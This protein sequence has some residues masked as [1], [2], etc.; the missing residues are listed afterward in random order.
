MTTRL[1]RGF[2]K[3]A[4]A[5]L[6]CVAAIACKRTEPRAD[7]QE[8]RSDRSPDATGTAAAS[9]A[10]ALSGFDTC[11]VGNFEAEQVTLKLEQVSAAGG[12]KVALQIGADGS[13][14]VDFTPMS[15]I[16]AKANGGLAFDFKYSGKASA[17]L[18][19]PER[20]TI[21]SESTNLDALRV[22]ATIKLP[23]AGGV[24]LFKD[25]PVN[26]LAKMATA[27]AGSMPQGAKLPGGANPASGIDASPVFSS[28]RYTCQG[29]TLTL[30]NVGGAA[31]WTFKRTP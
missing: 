7:T 28:S 13:S 5:G 10:V 17:T 14:S 18:K 6:G 29:D 22:S 1:G 19:T 20:G 3:F 4:I 9:A 2:A 25:T 11:L 27:I 26:E 16:N 8:T 15:P 23:G 30:D 24:P 12:S 21:V 31:T